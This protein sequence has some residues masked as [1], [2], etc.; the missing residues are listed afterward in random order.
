M[1][2][3][4]LICQAPGADPEPLF[5][6]SGFSVPSFNAPYA[7][8][9]E[10]IAS[11]LL[12]GAARP[13]AAE[14][15]IDRLATGLIEAIRRRTG[16][17]GGI[18]DFLHIYSLSTKEG[19]ALMVL[20]EAL[21]RVPD[22][23]T[24]DRLIE[25]KLATGDWSAA[26]SRSNTL[27]VSASAWTLGITARIIHPSETP[28]TILEGLIR[29]LGLP[30][31]RT[32]TREAMRLLGSHFVLG[33]TIQEALRRAG[34]APRRHS[35]DML[36][37]GARTADDAARYLA[38]YASAIDAIGASAGDRTLP[39]RPGIS[40]K[41][42]ALHPRFE[43]VSRQRVL[44]ELVP[45]LIELA[46]R[47]R[48][49]D[50]NFTVDAEEADRLELSLE[51][52]AAVLADPSL[53]GWEGFGLAVQAYQKRAA[54]VI[55]WLAETAQA[56]RRRLMV[57]LVKG[58]YWDS[59]IKR[60]QERGLADYPVFTRK[61]MT[62][63][64]YLACAN[65]LLAARPRLYP[66]FATHNALTVASV[67][68]D[69]GGVADYEFQRLHGMGEVLYE[70]LLAELPQAACRIYAP[71]GGHRDL[72]AY[73]V[74]RLLENGANS[75][76]VSAAADL[77]VPIASLL[78]RPQEAIGNPPQARHRSIPLPRDLYGPARRN[79]QG[80]EFGEQAALIG[81]LA[82]IHQATGASDAAP[83]V[84]GVA[85]A[86]RTRAVRSPIDGVT[87]G[88]VTEA[89]AAMAS[90]A[91]LRAEAGFAAW[92]AVAVDRRAD[93]LERAGDLLQA[94]R[95]WLI[96]LM[97]REAGKTLDDAL[98]ELR[99][100]IDFCRYYAA[101]ARRALAPHPMPG[102][103]GESNVLRYRGRGVFVCI[104]PWNFPLSIFLGQVAAAL[105]A[106][107]SVVAKPAEQTPLIAAE[108]VRILH[109]AGVPA[110]VLH[111]VPGDG[112]VGAAL[113]A[114]GRVAGVAFTGSTAV[115]RI[116]NGV[117][118]GAPSLP[119]AAGGG[120]PGRGGGPARGPGLGRGIVPLIAET[121]GINP[122]IVDATALP[123]QVTDDVI[124]SAFRSAGQRCSALRLLCVQDDTAERILAMV[125][126]AARE[127]KLGDPREP[128][129]HVGPVIDGE[130]K[131]RLEAWIANLPAQ[132]RL[133][134]RWDQFGA[135]PAEGTYVPPMIVELERASDLTEEVFGPILHVV[136]WR[137]DELEDLLDDILG[138][139]T[140]LTL[141]IHSRIDRT[142]NH[143]VARLGHGNVYVNRN[144]IGAVVGTQPFGGSGLSGTG[145]KAGGPD[146]LKRFAVE[147][148]VTTNT[149]AAGGNASL[150]TAE[151]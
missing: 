15:R 122:M 116:I 23:A 100:A 131:D 57:R 60:A 137:A 95:S 8:P 50:L 75:S 86:G 14:E 59:E 113:V 24:A 142:V 33:Q 112:Q 99:E 21:L 123:E 126:G 98:A 68:E 81:L 26:E 4:A 18:E 17:L 91:M 84:E 133:R 30:V 22:A 119:S 103:T 31:V 92:D 20:A 53:H 3:D 121:G 107:N 55:D 94:R 16:G 36:G 45:E 135:M 56:L 40:V 144:M 46:R 111:L 10:E 146:Y 114:D 90:D 19:L 139:R 44:K 71:V 77:G 78:K 110:S 7:S 27:L 39:D 134:F 136:R 118:A 12:A 65:K 97:Q 88:Q 145:P 38:A 151:E 120:G 63:L 64:C 93:A 140:G 2:P 115:A 42:S 69:A 5:S 49:H 61:P 109:E 108:A 32:A 143:I 13:A 34:T 104:S 72:L 138:N 124:A 82:E 130:A 125:E 54:A 28:D 41:L 35:F 9:D 149:A 43:P 6:A 47:A 11:R 141:G 1:T 117:L 101:E 67:I 150:L 29:R 70:M 79:S 83:V 132:A 87:I 127:L 74:R 25:D 148:V 105:V 37:E 106:G 129:T 85:L 76:F 80:V 96:A 128:S 48:R 102:P 58:A 89:D 73:L 147:Q 51:V 62:D 52:I 66:Q